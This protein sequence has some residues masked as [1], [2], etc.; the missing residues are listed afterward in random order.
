M[1]PLDVTTPRDPYSWNYREVADFLNLSVS[2]AEDGFEPLTTRSMRENL[3]TELSRHLGCHV[4]CTKKI[5][6][7]D[8]TSSLVSALPAINNTRNLASKMNCRALFCDNPGLSL[9]RVSNLSKKVLPTSRASSFTRDL[10][11]I[12]Q[13][14]LA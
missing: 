14:E 2:L 12:N 3:T 4:K 9:T 11:R 5:I 8:H 7:L 10:A 13:E 1:L 6:Q